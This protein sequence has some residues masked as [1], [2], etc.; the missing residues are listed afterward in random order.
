MA[1]EHIGGDTFKVTDPEAVLLAYQEWLANEMEGNGAADHP[2]EV[3][4]IDGYPM[5]VTFTRVTRSGEIFDEWKR[6]LSDEEI[7]QLWVQ[8]GNQQRG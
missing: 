7:H 2:V 4:P 5:N 8:S 1:Y 6:D 3:P